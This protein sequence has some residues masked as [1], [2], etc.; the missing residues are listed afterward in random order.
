MKI[1]EVSGSGPELVMLFLQKIE[2]M[3][4]SERAAVLRII[5][6]IYF[7]FGDVNKATEDKYLSL[8]KK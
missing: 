8:D 1:E 7:P 4:D 2:I 6:K 5:K 3:T